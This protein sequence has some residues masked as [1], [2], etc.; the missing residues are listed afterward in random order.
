[1][2]DELAFDLAQTAKVG[3]HH[4]VPSAAVDVE[5]DKAGDEHRIA[6]VNLARCGWEGTTGPRT[7]LRNASV[8]Y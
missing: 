7:D 5:I 4:I 6:E 3:F 1:M 2:G 8:F